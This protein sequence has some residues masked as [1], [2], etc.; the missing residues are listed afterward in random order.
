MTAFALALS[1]AACPPGY[2]QQSVMSMETRLAVAEFGN[3][4]GNGYE[5]EAAL[6]ANGG[7]DVFWSAVED[8]SL[9]GTPCEVMAYQGPLTSGYNAFHPFATSECEWLASDRL[10]FDDAPPEVW[11]WAKAQ[12]ILYHR[13]YRG[14]A[15]GYSGYC[16]PSEWFDCPAEVLIVAGPFRLAFS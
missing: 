14:P 13:G 2:I 4:Y 12:V 9:G 11:A 8:G 16:T 3:V 6:M 7:L 10:C 1:L 5:A 15:A